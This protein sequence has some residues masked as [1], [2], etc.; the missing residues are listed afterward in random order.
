MPQL[1]RRMNPFIPRSPSGDEAMN[2]PDED[3]KPEPGTD[4]AFYR[5]GHE[6]CQDREQR[7]KNAELMID[8]RPQ[9]LSAG[10]AENADQL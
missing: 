5:N 6:S 2:Q 9:R 3:I 10:G 8:Q 1:D 7:R 4:D